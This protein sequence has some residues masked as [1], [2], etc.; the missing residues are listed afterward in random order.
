MRKKCV[1]SLTDSSSK[2]QKLSCFV[3]KFFL[4]FA[5]GIIFASTSTV[6]MAQLPAPAY[7]PGFPIL[8]GQ[9]IMVMWAPVP[10]AAQYKV[11]RNDKLI[12]TTNAN[13]YFDQI[14]DAAGEFAYQVSAVGSDG[15]EGPKS[16][17]KSVKILKLEKP[18]NIVGRQIQETVGLRWE[19]NEAATAYNVYR[20]EKDEPDAYKLLASVTTSYYKDSTIELGKTYYYKVLAKDIAGKE[21]PPSKPFKLATQDARV[22][23]L[24]DAE[25]R[26]PVFA[27]RT[28]TV[29]EFRTGFQKGGV[30]VDLRAPFD[31]E[32]GEDAIFIS[33]VGNNRISAFSKKD[34]K[35]LFDLGK[36]GVMRGAPSEAFG[37]KRVTSLGMTPDRKVLYALDLQEKTIY[38]FGADGRLLGSFTPEPKMLKE[39]EKEF[40]VFGFEVDDEGNVWLPDVFNKK[41]RVFD[42]RGNE[43][44]SFR[45]GEALRNMT[46]TKLDFK[47][48]RYIV[49][50]ADPKN[51][52]VG[53]A[54]FDLKG[55]LKLEIKGKKGIGP[56]KL[57]APGGLDVMDDGSIVQ[58][59]SINAIINVFD[60]ETG[61]LKYHLLDEDGKTFVQVASVR[62]LRVEGDKIYVANSII[63][64]VAVLEM[65]GEPFIAEK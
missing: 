65:F 21:S 25:K 51:V 61:K 30:E 31:V 49:V 38:M 2:K 41:V 36:E 46:F 3:K 48:G 27:R 44:R 53:I 39:D 20:A 62:G 54:V 29:A 28:R 10:G 13:Q 35:H 9:Q 56:G 37:F 26:G 43:L 14:G 23:A 34:G 60:P 64:E 24:K 33:H 15:S 11:Y 5:V 17:A 59:D 52:G 22:I 55:N 6:C 32:I 50:N 58:A 63:D 12:T 57:W 4:P 18:K 45:H 42:T 1:N 16:E 19:G 47:H 7:L 40:R 8:A